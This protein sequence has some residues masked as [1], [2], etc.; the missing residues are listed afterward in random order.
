MTPGGVD[1]EIWAAPAD[2]TILDVSADGRAL[3]TA[4]S[5]H[6]DIKWLGPD[7]S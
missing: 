3:I 1:R 7:D 4:N 2:L 5:L 6:V